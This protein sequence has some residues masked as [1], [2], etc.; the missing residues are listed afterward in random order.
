VLA[1]IP[2]AWNEAA[3]VSPAKPS[4][5]FQSRLDPADRRDPQGTYLAYPE[6][7]I[8]HAYE[9]LAGV[10]R[11]ESES[12]FDYWGAIGHYWASLCGITRLTS[13]RYPSSFGSRTVLYVIGLSFSAEMAVKGAW[14][15]SIGAVTAWIRG[16]ERTP[17]D[18]FALLLAGDYARFLQR[19]PWYDFTFGERLGAFWADVPMSGGNALRRIE[20]R[21]ALSLEWGGKALY[22]GVMRSA[23][24]AA[25]PFPT[26]IRSVVKGLDRSDLAADPR[27][28][29]VSTLA[30]GS[31]IIETDRY[32]V[33]TEVIE[34][35]AKRGRDVIEIAG[36]DRVLVTLLVP[37]SEAV[38]PELELAVLEVAVQGRPGTRRAGH[39]VPVRL[40]GS[41]S[42][43]LGSGPV[44]IELVYDFY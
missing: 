31:S 44:R 26:R 15:R 1:A 19:S 43:S 35:L 13:S 3:C 23:A 6:W 14:E 37:Q 20:R 4:A 9:D 27:I 24:A 17:E 39:D 38:P 2:V 28:T 29:L 42:R 5:P 40:L 22:A 8:V 25:M 7:A 30:D 10:M 11:R 18:D 16:G 21:I 41:L 32:R 33:L 36:N 34:G 12:A